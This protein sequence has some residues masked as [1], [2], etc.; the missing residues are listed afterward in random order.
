[1][2]ILA[3]E[4]AEN[5]HYGRGALTVWCTIPENRLPITARMEAKETTIKTIKEMGVKIERNHL[6]HD[7]KEAL[8]SCVS[9]LLEEL[10]KL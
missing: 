1:M 6:N 7:D 3:N 9:K 5:L 2:A 10:K 8:K 4:Y